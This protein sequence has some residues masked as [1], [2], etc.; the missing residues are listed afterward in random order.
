MADC[1]KTFDAAAI[2]MYTYDFGFEKLENNPY[3]LI[4]KNIAG[5]NFSGLQQVKDLVF[6][7]ISAL[8]K[9]PRVEGRTLYRGVRAEVNMD[10]DHYFE[11]N[12]IK[13][14]RAS[15]RERV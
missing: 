12:T 10:E 6:L 3:R 7:V 13:I 15:C 4:N 9:L 8:R 1:Q 2:A 5:R 11:G 14:G